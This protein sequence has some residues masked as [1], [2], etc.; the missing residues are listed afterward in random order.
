MPNNGAVIT[1]APDEALEEGELLPSE[2]S[3]DEAGEVLVQEVDIATFEVIHLSDKDAAMLETEE[4]ITS[5]QCRV[6]VLILVIQY[7]TS[8]H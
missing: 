4:D 8:S 2:V 3:T 1:I 7:C 6:S 5:T